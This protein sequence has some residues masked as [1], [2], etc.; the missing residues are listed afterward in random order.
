[1]IVDDEIMASK[2]LKVM[3]GKYFDQPYEI[4]SETDFETALQVIHEYI[5]DVLL[6]DVMMPPRTGFDLLAL[7]KNRNFKLI[8]TTAYDNYAIQAIKY[9]ALDYLLKPISADELKQALEKVIET[10]VD[11]NHLQYNHLLENLQSKSTDNFTIAIPTLEKTFFIHPR[12]LV[13]C[14]S[15][16]N[17]TW[18]YLTNGEKILT[19]KTLKS[20]DTILIEQGFIRTHRSHLVNKHHIKR[21][22][23]ND[24]LVLSDETML[25]IA[26][27]KKESFLEMMK[28]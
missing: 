19:S 20:Y 12:D 5:P 2:T 11:H 24:V 3:I 8:F 26:R 13:R 7:I 28:K 14:E 6:L 22:E 27:G 18:F 16:S 25:P 21:I 23:K 10:T 17:Y 15:E 9:S 1:M 4:R